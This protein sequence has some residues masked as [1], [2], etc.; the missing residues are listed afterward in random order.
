[1]ATGYSLNKFYIGLDV[2]TSNCGISLW[3]SDGV[4]KELKHIKLDVEST[5]PEEDRYIYKAE[6]FKDYFIK[7]KQYIYD[8]YD[9]VVDGVFIEKPL[10]G[11]VKNAH[12]VALLLGFNGIV[13]YIAYQIFNVPPLLISVHQSRKIFLPEFVTKK[14]TL[15]FPKGWKS[16]EKKMYIWEK[17]SKIYP[18]IKWIYKKDGVTPKDENFDMSDSVAV[19]YSSLKILGIIN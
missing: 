11:V 1:M 4:L 18:D 5:I 19:G 9:G 2:S 14:G 6:I 7:Y 3:D 15:S 13:C 12:T 10:N 16:Y 17:V 8:Q